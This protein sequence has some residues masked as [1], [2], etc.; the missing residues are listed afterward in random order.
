MRFES[1]IIPRYLMSLTV[2]T[3]VF[4]QISLNWAD[5]SFVVQIF[6]K[7][8]ILDD[9]GWNLQKLYSSEMDQNF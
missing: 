2:L 5:P 9:N 1:T 6:D 7:I 4:C 8:F 3:V